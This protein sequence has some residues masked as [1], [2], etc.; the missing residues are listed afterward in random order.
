MRF[1]FQ[2]QEMPALQRLLT[3]DGLRNH[4]VKNNL[5]INQRRRCALFDQRGR[6]FRGWI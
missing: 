4:G 6:E 1:D 5:V 3:V 2:G